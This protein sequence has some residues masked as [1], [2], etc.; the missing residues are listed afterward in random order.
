M[1]AA[2]D[3]LPGIA[4]RRAATQVGAIYLHTGSKG[5]PLLLLHG[6]P[7]T[8]FRLARHATSVVADLPG[9]G[10]RGIP[11]GDVGHVSYA[12]LLAEPGTRNAQPAPL[13]VARSQRLR[14]ANN[15]AP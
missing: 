1:N 5:L 9:Y 4:E 8:H 6:D 2:A 15:A 11:P 12:Q 14:S 7:L 10:A 3:G 13:G